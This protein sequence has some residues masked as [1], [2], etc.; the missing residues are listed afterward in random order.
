MNTLLMKQQREALGLTQED[1]AKVLKRDRSTVAGWEIGRIVPDPRLLPAL[2]KLLQV[3]ADDLLAD[4]P[5]ES[6]PEV[7]SSKDVS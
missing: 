3:T 5:M 2:A 4:S 7:A 6:T 1:I